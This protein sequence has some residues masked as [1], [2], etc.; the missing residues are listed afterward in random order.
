MH[1]SDTADHFVEP[2]RLKIADF[3]KAMVVADAESVDPFVEHQHTV[4]PVAENLR[5]VLPMSQFASSPL[6]RD[7]HEPCDHI[8]CI[9]CTFR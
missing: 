2:S 4:S 3:E 6:S 7:S 8:P 9:R 1:E 5:R